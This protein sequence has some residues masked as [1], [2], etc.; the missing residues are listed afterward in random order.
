MIVFWGLVK[1]KILKFIIIVLNFLFLKGKNLVFFWI[2]FRLGLS[3]LV[4]FNILLEKFNLI[5]LYLCLVVF[6]VI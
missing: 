1:C 5:I 6:V 2:N 4:L 3:C